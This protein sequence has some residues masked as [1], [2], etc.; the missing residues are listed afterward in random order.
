MPDAPSYDRLRVTDEFEAICARLVSDGLPF[1]FDIETS[2]D[3]E[4]REEAQLHPEEDFICGLSLTN[5]VYW[6]RYGALHHDDTS[7]NLDNFRCA[8]SFWGLVQ[9]G[10]GIAHGAKFELRHLSRWFMEHLADHPLLGAAVR[11]AKGY[12]P[13]RSDTMLESYV[14][15]RNRVHGLKD[16]TLAN[17]GHKMTEIFELF[18][19]LT[20]KQQKS[21]RFSELD[22]A[23]PRVYSY[24]CEDSLWALRHHMRRYPVVCDT[25]IYKLEMQVLPVICEMEDEGV[26]YD[27]N[28]IREGAHRARSFL[29]KL[30]AEVGQLLTDLVRAKDPDA[31]A[32]NINLGSSQQI[33]KVLYD[34]L[35]MKTRRRTDSGSMST[36]KIALKTLA[37]QYPV[38]K[39]ITHWKSL[40]KLLGT[41]LEPYPVK[42]SYAPDGRTHPSHLQ[43]GV[44][45]GRFAVLGPPY[46]QSP[47]KYHFEL[48]TGETFD[49]NFRD[50]I[51]SP[52]GWY[53][54]G[55]D[56]AQ[57]ELR[58]LAGE[59]GETAMIE[60]FA[61]GIDVHKRTAALMFGKELDEVVPEERSIG[62]TIGLALGYQLGVDGLADRLGVPNE[63]AQELYD[64]FFSIY[65]RIKG[66]LERTIAAAKAQGYIVTKFGRVVRIW[67]FESTQ[68]HIYAQGERL[69]GNA[70]IQGA[71]TGD[72]PKIAMVRARKALRD[73]GLADKVKLVMNVHDALEF[74][75]RDDVSPGEII[76]VL[77]PAVVFPV[78]GWPPIVAEWHVGRKWGS[79]RDV[80]LLAD[81]SIRLKDEAPATPVAEADGDPDEPSGGERSPALVA[82]LDRER[83][84]RGTSP[85][86]ADIVPVT[87]YEVL[88]GKI[89]EQPPAASWPQ[90]AGLPRKIIV[91]MQ[92]MPGRE[93]FETLRSG[94][95]SQPGA[96]TWTLAVPGGTYAL[97]T[98][99]FGPE[100]ESQ[101]SVLLG[102]AM[103][104]YDLD[105]VDT[106]ALTDGLAF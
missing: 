77:Q 103:V 33:S 30:Q 61:L 73:A 20:K 1:G 7:R 55:F 85:E 68:R 26:Y 21:I 12:F 80:E 51:C 60:A 86:L 3:G 91:T 50:A 8:V 100:I 63:R 45:A 97:G 92:G 90:Y 76:R 32:I 42:Y 35:G 34:Q 11:A 47:K 56:Y 40:K 83:A 98:S 99:A 9:T 72:Y 82:V 39:R 25:F 22:P 88:A 43:H 58:V 17:F 38:V 10:L 15:A 93:Q 74:Y 5:S 64:T 14:E 28:H 66:Y 104:T 70:P 37:E 57:Q 94:L 36:D 27:W 48:A 105:S 46:Q 6:A 4:P 16:I 102:G 71:G 78:D 49:F 13:I 67:E 87:G 31:D 29:E 101:L 44:P 2:Y 41:Y 89:A 23:D 24:A 84:T 53:M 69:A 79:V 19:K 81:G 52:P 75:A 54:I 106:A 95:A 59:A 62:K 18:G 65:S 96:N